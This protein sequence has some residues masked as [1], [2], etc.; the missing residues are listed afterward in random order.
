MGELYQLQESSP[1]N[2]DS[3]RAHQAC[4]T[5]T[6]AMGYGPAIEL[7]IGVWNFGVKSDTS[8][9]QQK[10]NSD[11]TKRYVHLSVLIVG[12]LSSDECPRLTYCWKFCSGVCCCGGGSYGGGGGKYSVPEKQD[13]QLYILIKGR[14]YPA[15]RMANVKDTSVLKLVR[16]V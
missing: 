10:K 11:S 13:W 8:L 12:L 6:G 3:S 9:D 16:L 7:I 1:V 15:V 14:K 5:V 4:S 2:H